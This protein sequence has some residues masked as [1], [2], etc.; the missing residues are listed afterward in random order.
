MSEEKKHMFLRPAD[1]ENCTWRQ[2]YNVL[3]YKKNSVVK[4]KSKEKSNKHG[5]PIV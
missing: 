5:F 4:N 2:V 1:E 3:F